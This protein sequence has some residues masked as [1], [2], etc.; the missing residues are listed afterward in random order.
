MCVVK[1]YSTIFSRTK[2][3]SKRMSA[4]FTRFCHLPTLRCSVFIMIVLL[5]SCFTFGGEIHDAAA[6]G[7]LEK[8][9]ALLK[10]NPDLVFSKEEKY[11]DTP[12]HKA[13]GKGHKN[14]VELL[15]AE[16]AD[17]N[18]TNNDGYTPLH[19]AA[20]QGDK[21]V[22]AMLL[23]NKANVNAKDN[24]GQTPLLWAAGS[25]RKDVAELLLG[26]GADV[27]AKK[28]I[29]LTPLAMAAMKGYR[30]LVELLLTNK[31]DINAKDNNG[32]TPLFLAALKGH[33]DVAEILLAGK[34]DVNAKDHDG[35]T[36][37]QMAANNGYKDLA[38]LLLANS[39]EVNAK[40]NDGETV[41]H[42][43]ALKG[44]TDMAE[45]L[46]ANG[47]N[48][49]SKDTNGQTPLHYAMAHGNGKVAELLRQ[50][51]GHEREFNA[52]HPSDA[53]TES[54][55][56]GEPPA[57]WPA[58]TSE[59]TGLREVR[60]K[61]PNAFKVRVGLR[62]DGKGKDFIVPP[63]GTESLNVPDGRYAIY[64][65]Y[66]SDPDALYQG[67]GFTLENNDVEIT[68]KKVVNGNYGIRKVK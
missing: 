47:A 2:P 61:N 35:V 50:H 21:D 11:G 64:F 22:A 51:G 63:N 44:D 13:T 9:K 32:M 16:K 38:M 4:C 3:D 10:D 41:L 15:L 56:I 12:L 54:A 58:Y 40:A 7:D 39:A 36:P 25:D 24:Y 27:N 68:I 20:Y 14:V 67:D 45:L 8:V 6:K 29:G 48:V 43:V 46:L 37:L 42:S 49:N 55:K 31:A 59:L 30:D 28:N 52:G 65:N 34:A 60:V 53:V 17:V 57:N 66:S 23:A 1:N 26:D 18:A 5:W 62:S 19:V 33:T